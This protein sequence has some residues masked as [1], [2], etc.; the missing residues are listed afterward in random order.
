ME[1]LNGPFSAEYGDFPGIGVAHV[2]L[3][4]SLAEKFL[5]RLQGESFR[6]YRTF[7]GPSTDI[8]MADSFRAYLRS[9]TNG[10][11]HTHRIAWQQR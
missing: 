8:P 9:R 6:S 1:I 11:N 4:E 7:L 5:R 3:K 10:P 2:R